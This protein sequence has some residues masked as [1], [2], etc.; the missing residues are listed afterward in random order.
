MLRTAFIGN[1]N[2]FDRKMCEWLSEHTELGL[3][4]WT[5]SMSWSSGRGSSAARKRVERFRSRARRYGVFR[6]ANEILYFIIYRALYA[7]EEQRRLRELVRSRE[8]SA[9][10]K[11]DDIR[12]IRPD[13]IST[14]ELH[15]AVQSERLDAMFAMCID[16]YLPERLVQTPRLG[17][18]LWHEGI[19]PEYRGVHSPFWA[20]ANGDHEN[21][22]YTLL[23]M[24]SKLDA[25]DVYVQ[26][27]VE[28]IDPMKDLH[29]YIGHKAIFD[30]LPGVRQFLDDLEAGRQ[31]V[32]SRP[33]ARDRYYSYPTGTKL[34][35][36]MLWRLA[37][38]VRRRRPV[39]LYSKRRKRNDM[40][41]DVAISAST[42]GPTVDEVREVVETIKA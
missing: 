21:L 30:S 13:S 39:S 11:L 6:T 35:K 1:D 38:H 12:Q 18:Y 9:K 15:N 36:I 25:G 17:T 26:G 7:A 41:A 34:L 16:V 10:T 4:I 2:A 8:F 20:L 24:N 40:S 27:K 37:D 33:E 31:R 28:R 23:K 32:I 42:L 14:D 19:T 22:G 29:C 3:I 5:N